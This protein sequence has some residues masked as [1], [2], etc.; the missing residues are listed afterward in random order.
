[1]ENKSDGTVISDTEIAL[2]AEMVRKLGWEPGDQLIVSVFAGDTVTLR[3]RSRRQQTDF[4][5][6]MMGDV[7]GSHDDVMRY[8]AEE[9]ASWKES[10]LASAPDDDR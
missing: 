4:L 1:M 9:R 2:P 8:L 6:G 7:W 10:A 3:R 5:A